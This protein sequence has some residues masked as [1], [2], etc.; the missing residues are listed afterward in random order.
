MLNIDEV[1]AVLIS[2]KQQASFSFYDV[3]N[4]KPS[5]HLAKHSKIRS[6]L[7]LK[8]TFFYNF[9]LP[10]MQGTILNKLMA[11]MTEFYPQK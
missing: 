10:M 2:S 8:G 3:A 6:R 1:K 11:T 5:S 9:S 7:W 4:V